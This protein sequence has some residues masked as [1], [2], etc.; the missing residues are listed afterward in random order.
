MVSVIAAPCSEGIGLFDS[1]GVVRALRVGCDGDVGSRDLSPFH[2][3][4]F[5]R[6]PV[7]TRALRHRRNCSG[8]FRG[9][10]AGHKGI[11]ISEARG[12][13]AGHKGIR[14]YRSALYRFVSLG[15]PEA[16]GPPRNW[17]LAGLF[18]KKNLPWALHDWN[19]LSEMSTKILMAKW[20]I[21]C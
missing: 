20:E 17:N 21:Q 11:Q 16:E 2:W 1:P 19:F 8:S 3:P 13:A 18:F 6:N 12:T 9:T 14:E 10:A 5:P 15:F 4:H 7:G